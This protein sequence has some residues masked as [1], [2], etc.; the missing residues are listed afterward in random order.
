MN[1]RATLWALAA[2]PAA[3][4]YA[5]LSWGGQAAADALL[6]AAP[7]SLAPLNAE[8]S[9]AF[10]QAHGAADAWIEP[11]SALP[12]LLALEHGAIDVA[13]ID[14]ELS[15][16]EDGPGRFSYLIA[17][18]AVAIVTNA[19]LPITALSTDQVRALF[20]GA[21]GNW[22][23]LGAPPAAVRPFTHPRGSRHSACFDH[24]VLGDAEVSAE[25]NE[26]ADP[27]AMVR[28][29]ASDPAAIGYL[30]LAASDAAAGLHALAIDGV[31]ATRA[32]VLSGR[33]GLVQSL[34]LVIQGDAL[35]VAR[36][37]VAFVR[38]NAGQDIVQRHLLTP[39]Y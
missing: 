23:E 4:G 37:F 22:E 39:V 36:A 5:C 15:T 10:R 6:I 35:P 18:R 20:A 11:G 25:A 13:M 14:R 24:I 32:T 12:A 31:R 30:P 2:I 38:S 19:A 33:Y 34:H 21:I 8:L 27:R 28:Q 7:D 3:A 9:Q 1:K 17:R 16:A 26:V 29:V